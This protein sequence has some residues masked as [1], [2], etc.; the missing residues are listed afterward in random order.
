MEV[1]QL[2][3]GEVAQSSTQDEQQ[4]YLIFFFLKRLLKREI[5]YRKKRVSIFKLDLFI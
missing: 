1:C 5:G 4:A 3:K 2:S